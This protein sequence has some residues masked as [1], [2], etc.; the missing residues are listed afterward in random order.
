M[1][2]DERTLLQAAS[3]GNRPLLPAAAAGAP[4]ANDELGRRLLLR[5]GAAFGLTP[6]RNRM[7]AARCLALA[8]AV[9]MVDRVHRHAAR[10]G[11]HTLPTVT[12][13]LADAD[14]FGLGVAD[15]ANGGP[16]VDRNPAHLGA[17][18]TERRVL[19]FLGDELHAHAGAAGHL[20]AT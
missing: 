13:G 1:V 12:T 10:L 15:F 9:R 17:R 14:E 19:A 16:A 11:T 18:Q 4:A 3:H 5:T 2:V 20:A 6:R 7:T 8:A